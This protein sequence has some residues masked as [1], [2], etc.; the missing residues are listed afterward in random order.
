MGQ[1]YYQFRCRCTWTYEYYSSLV[2]CSGLWTVLLVQSSL[3]SVHPSMFTQTLM[4][5]TIVF[6]GSYYLNAARVSPEANAFIQT[7]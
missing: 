5:E 7:L 3:F 4:L 6:N 1:V 2:S